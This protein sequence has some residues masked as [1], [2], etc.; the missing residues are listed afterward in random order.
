M[1]FISLLHPFPKFG[2]MKV[3]LY[4]YGIKVAGTHP[5]LPLDNINNYK[6]IYTALFFCNSSVAGD[7][8]TPYN[9]IFLAVNPFDKARYKFHR[10]GLVWAS[11]HHA[12]GIKLSSAVCVNLSKL[13]KRVASMIELY[14]VFYKLIQVWVI[15]YPF[16]LIKSLFTTIHISIVISISGRVLPI[17]VSTFIKIL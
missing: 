7:K 6:Y 3:L 11:V 13:W 9:S 17:G 12:F 14:G 2:I 15:N 10:R 4:K 1:L 8:K 5:P 16:F